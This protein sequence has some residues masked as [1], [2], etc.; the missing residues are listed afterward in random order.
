MDSDEEVTIILVKLPNLTASGFGTRYQ[1]LVPEGFG[2]QTL[3]RFVYSGCRAIALNE[4][5]AITLECGTSRCFPY[6][7]PETAAGREWSSIV[8]SD[9][10]QKYVLKP[11]SKR[12]N[13]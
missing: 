2:L 8:N 3:R 5:L 6:D 12:V 1:V 10:M 11:P 7:F 4:Y 9:K 13:Y